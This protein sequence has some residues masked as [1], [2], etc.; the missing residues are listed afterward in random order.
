MKYKPPHLVAIFLGLFLLG[1]GG[2]MAPLAPPGSATVSP[3][4]T[5]SA[6]TGQEHDV[7]ARRGEQG[8][9]GGGR[10]FGNRNR[11]ITENT[12]YKFASRQ[13]QL[14]DLSR[15]KASTTPS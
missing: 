10:Q 8:S 11:H 5:Q 14:N 1:R 2:G 15:V 6:M 12:L 7:M 13:L 9:Q 3:V 4:Q